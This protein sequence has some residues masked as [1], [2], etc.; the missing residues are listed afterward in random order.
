[1]EITFDKKLLDM[2]LVSPRQYGELGLFTIDLPACGGKLKVM[3]ED[4]Q[5][6]EIPSYL[7]S[8]EGEHL[9]LWVEKKGLSAD[10]LTQILAKKLDIPFRDIGMAGKKDKHAITQQFVSVPLSVKE[11]VEQF[12]HPEINIISSKAHTNKLSVSHTKG[13]H[14]KVVLRD[15]ENGDPDM[16]KETAER[17]STCGFPNFFGPQRFG[18]KG[19]TA[20]IGFKIMRGEVEGLPRHWFNKG[21]KKFALSAAQSYL[22]NR[23]LLKRLVEK[24]AKTLLNGD[25]VFKTTGGIFRVDDLET[26]TKRFHLNEI[27]PAGPIFGKKTFPAENEALQFEE[28]LLAE[29]GLDRKCFSEFGKMMM[30]TRRSM[31]CIP[32]N[33]KY[34]LEGKNLNL[35]FTLPSGSYATVLLAEFMKPIS[36]ELS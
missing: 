18:A 30:G 17:I 26:E 35:E 13:N 4:F 8:G 22:F 36:V 21:K 5:V 28:D 11:R 16:I 3:P 25:V 24:G 23:Y 27:V 19:D 20:E 32:K 12:S 7:P 33:F 15:M 29:A 1:M 6:E 34:H 14:F 10:E 9:F 31:F 2:E